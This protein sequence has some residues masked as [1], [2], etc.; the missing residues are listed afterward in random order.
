[1][2]NVA[3]PTLDE[4]RDSF[5]RTTPQG[6]TSPSAKELGT[7]AK[8]I[9]GISIRPG[10]ITLPLREA[11]NHSSG[12][13]V[14]AFVSA[15]AAIG[16]IPLSIAFNTPGALSLILHSVWLLPLLWYAGRRVQQELVLSPSSPRCSIRHGPL[17]VASWHLGLFFTGDHHL[18]LSL[19]LGVRTVRKTRGSSDD[20]ARAAHTLNRY[21][22]FGAA[23]AS[24]TESSDGA[25][26]PGALAR[27]ILDSFRT[28]ELDADKLVVR[29]IS[30]EILSGIAASL[31][32]AW[33]FGLGLMTAAA[34]PRLELASHVILL[35]LAALAIG[36][37][38]WEQRGPRVT[39]LA[40]RRTVEI[41]NRAGRKEML[42]LERNAFLP[43]TYDDFSHLVFLVPSHDL[44]RVLKRIPLVYHVDEYADLDRIVDEMLLFLGLPIPESGPVGDQPVPTAPPVT[45]WKWTD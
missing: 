20:L 29:G 30:Y 14:V 22:L 27:A 36:S 41:R 45:E 42:V 31:L 40:G 3:G 37:Y 44:R 12:L 33:M 25:V 21:I 23:S 18:G 39:L 15:A 19:H 10:S 28:L 9:P 7:L 43:E 2:T 34:F 38:W 4:L 16:A 8:T 1:M 32:A 11:R 24:S 26:L 35:A 13:A 17:L 5:R 6:V